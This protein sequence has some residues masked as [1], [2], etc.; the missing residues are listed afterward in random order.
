MLEMG[1]PQNV[2]DALQI[3]HTELD[4]LI[5]DFDRIPEDIADFLYPEDPVIVLAALLTVKRYTTSLLQ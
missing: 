4:G 2:V 5:R 1:T 3:F